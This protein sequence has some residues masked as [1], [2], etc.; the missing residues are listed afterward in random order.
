MKLPFRFQADKPGIYITKVS[1]S[2]G[3]DIREFDVQVHCATHSD[4][5]RQTATLHMRTSVFNPVQ[6]NLPLVCREQP[7]AFSHALIDPINTF[8]ANATE[9]DWTMAVTFSGNKAFSGPKSFRVE[10]K[11][12]YQYPLTF[13]PQIEDDTFQAQLIIENAETGFTQTYH[14]RGK[15]D[16]GPPVS[17][18]AFYAPTFCHRSIV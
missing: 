3:N 7:L 11:S 4:S 13:H 1:L 18:S 8:Q 17:P 6:Q 14:L 5:D 16:R 12:V 2:C 9:N 10:A 15:A